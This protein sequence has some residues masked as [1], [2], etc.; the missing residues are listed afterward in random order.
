MLG[1]LTPPET[2]NEIFGNT[3]RYKPKVKKQKR[4]NFYAD[5]DDEVQVSSS[6]T[7][8]FNEDSDE[9]PSEHSE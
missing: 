3:F 7:D 6:S 4:T 8:S 9:P 5:N 2:D 1:S